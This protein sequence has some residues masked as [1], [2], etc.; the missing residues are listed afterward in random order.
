MLSIRV[1]ANEKKNDGN[2]ELSYRLRGS[3]LAALGERIRRMRD[4]VGARIVA[5]TGVMIFFGSMLGAM[6]KHGALT[7]LLIEYVSFRFV[8]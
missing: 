5:S 4:T 1:D 7:A 6:M 3:S 2:F 8:L